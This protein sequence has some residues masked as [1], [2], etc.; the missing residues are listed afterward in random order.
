MTHLVRR[1]PAELDLETFARLTGL[2][3]ELARRL[4]CLGLLEASSDAAG[5]LWIPYSQ[6]AVAGRIQRLRGGFALNYAALG[7]VMDLLDHIA[8]LEAALRRQRGL[9][10]ARL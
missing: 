6:I 3:P 5:G 10:K 4:V 9:S 1:E 7:L 2:H 8:E